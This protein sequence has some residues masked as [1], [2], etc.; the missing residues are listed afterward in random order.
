MLRPRRRTLVIAAA[1]LAV[2]VAAVALPL[3]QPW[4]LL[5]DT[6]VD[7]G[8]PG[9]GPISTAPS[10]TAAPTISGSRR[11]TDR[12]SPAPPSTNQSGPSSTSR[13]SAPGTSAPGTKQPPKPPAE[14]VRL[15]VGTFISHEHQTSGTVAVY[16]LADGSH[17]LRLENLNTSDGPD[18]KVWLTDAPVIEGRGGWHVFDDGRYANL[19]KLKGNHG[20]QNYPLPAGLDPTSFSSVSIWC[21][22]FNVSFGAA[23]LADA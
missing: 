7:E 15:S 1:A 10:S 3:F 23:A 5:T 2:A 12:P 8:L 14:P 11:S 6:V 21:D 20:N 22:R 18:L 13:P 19:G 17:V 4:R 9:S 16:K